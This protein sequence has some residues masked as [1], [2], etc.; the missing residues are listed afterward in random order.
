MTFKI[1]SILRWACYAIA[2]AGTAAAMWHVDHRADDTGTV[3]AV[4]PPQRGLVLPAAATRPVSGPDTLA[5]LKQRL[6]AALSGGADPFSDDRPARGAAPAA[7]PVAAAATA[8]PAAPAMPYSYVGRWVDQGTTEVFLQAASRVVSVR[9]PGPLEDGYAVEAIGPE[10][11]TIK[12][13]A[14]E[15]YTVSF[16]AAGG[17]APGGAPSGQPVT[18]TTAASPA[19]TPEEN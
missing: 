18:S 5:V 3:Q 15:R 4:R 12:G 13:A 1:P 11:L 17:A 10:G 8:A 19:G 2:A 6:D 9:G 14:G 16:A 7:A